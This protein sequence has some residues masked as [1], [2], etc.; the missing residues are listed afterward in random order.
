MRTVLLLMPLGATC[1]TG[2][3]YGT[4]KLNAGRSTFAGDTRP[5]SLTIRIEPHTKGEVFT[6]DRIEADGRASSSS[7][8]LYLDGREREFRD[9]ECFGTQS[10]RRIDSRTIEILRNCGASAWTRFVRRTAPKNQLVLEIL[11][12]HADGRRSDRRLEFEKQ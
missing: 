11:E 7:T 2:A 12:Q 6:L 5:R 1:W 8:L 4:W 9:G 3:P 10:S